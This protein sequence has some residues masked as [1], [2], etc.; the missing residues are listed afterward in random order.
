MPFSCCFSGCQRTQRSPSPPSARESDHEGPSNPSPA[1][2]QVSVSLLVSEI[3]N[4]YGNQRVTFHSPSSAPA[5]KRLVG[6]MT[7]REAITTMADH[8]RGALTVI[9]ELMIQSR[10]GKKLLN[11]LDDAGIYG[12]Q[13]W[14]LYRYVGSQD[15][16]RTFRIVLNLLNNRV[17][18]NDLIAMI[19]NRQRWSGDLGL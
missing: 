12:E 6:E 17:S 13:I 7:V 16:Q 8:N 10:N 4:A 3:V 18:A 19:N 14:D 1:A 11:K 2:A 15:Y 5:G 9:N